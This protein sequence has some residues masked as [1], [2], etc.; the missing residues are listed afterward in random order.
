MNIQIAISNAIGN[1]FIGQPSYIVLSF[2]MR[3]LADGGTFEAPLC[4]NS[5]LTSLQQIP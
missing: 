5:F 2:E 3:V 4:L 1:D